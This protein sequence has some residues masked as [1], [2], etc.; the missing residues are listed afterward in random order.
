[1]PEAAV[2]VVESAQVLE[3]YESEMANTCVLNFL[4]CDV[5]FGT[6]L[7]IFIFCKR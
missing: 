6:G 4:A 7:M 2:V 1:V 5:V 3:K